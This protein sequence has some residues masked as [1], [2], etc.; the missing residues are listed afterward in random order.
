MKF[1]HIADLHID[2]PFVNLSDRENLGEIRR[3][4][5]RKAIRKVVEYI[6]ENEIPYLFIS[7]DMYEHQYIKKSTIQY[8][9]DLFREIPNTHIYIAPGNHDPYLQN[10]YYNQFDWNENV[11]IFKSEIEN[12][13]LPDV[14]IYGYGFN[15]FYCT[16]SGIEEF[17]IQDNSKLNILIIHGTLNGATTEEKQYNSMSKNMLESKGFDYIALGHIHKISYKDEEN[18]KIVYPG[19]TVSLG[20]DELGKHGMIVGDIEKGKIRL[21]FVQIDEKE[22]VE[23]EIDITNIISKEELIETLN[24]QVF[25]QNKFVK[26]ILTG[27]RNFEIDTYNLY[28][29]VEN[30]QII[31]LKNKTKINYDLNKIANENTLKGMFAQE[32]IKKINNENLTQDEKEMLEKTIEIAFEALD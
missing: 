2:S 5:Q 19:S 14:N 31:K 32:M 22:F 23:K 10:S 4:D 26:I 27:K 11:H 30:K 17:N 29:F 12:I 28:K 18:Q 3:L 1:V 15:N 21:E 24:G 6:K 13:E 9:N 20:F 8:I 7:G 25:D 16:N